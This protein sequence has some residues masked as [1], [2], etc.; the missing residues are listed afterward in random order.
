ME[1]ENGRHG[2]TGDELL[3]FGWGNVLLL[4]IM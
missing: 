1:P 2:W 3:C 4:C